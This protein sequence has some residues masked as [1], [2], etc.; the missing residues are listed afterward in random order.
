M[1]GKTWHA[2]QVDP[3]APVATANSC[4]TER[5]ASA[6]PMILSY[7]SAH[8]QAYNGVK[9]RSRHGCKAWDAHAKPPKHGSPPPCSPGGLSGPW[10]LCLSWLPHP[11]IPSR[12]IRGKPTRRDPHKAQQKAPGKALCRTRGPQSKAASRHPRRRKQHPAPHQN[13]VGP[14]RHHPRAHA[15]LA[16]GRRPALAH[17]GPRG[18]KTAPAK[19]RGRET[20]KILQPRRRAATAH[21]QGPPP[22]LHGQANPRR[23]RH[24]PRRVAASP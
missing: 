6:T 18:H 7:S 3:H 12:T 14:L 8:G 17:E 1:G 2:E 23:A 10:G 11:T 4:T 16:Q 24:V 15:S 5:P 21:D 20:G 9:R 13:G 19:K 22:L